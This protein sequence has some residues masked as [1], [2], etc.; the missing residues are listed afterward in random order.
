M[1][2]RAVAGSLLIFPPHCNIIGLTWYLNVGALG[3]ILAYLR[4]T[5][6]SGW[7]WNYSLLILGCEV[8]G[9]SSPAV[10]PD[11]SAHSR[12]P[13]NFFIQIGFLLC[14]S[15]TARGASKSWHRENI[16]WGFYRLFVG[17][18]VILC[19]PALNPK[20]H[21]CRFSCKGK[22]AESSAT[23]HEA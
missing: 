20:R 13:A 5:L 1:Q 8:S 17:G 22:T 7:G 16:R 23:Q 9:V 19:L 11:L 12:G 15:Q 3:T 18:I 10:R 6:L 21:R 14:E 4:N 2:A